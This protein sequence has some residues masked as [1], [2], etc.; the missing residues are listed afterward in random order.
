MRESGN[1]FKLRFLSQYMKIDVY[2]HKQ[3]YENW[4]RDVVE[5][6]EEGLT[7]ENS[8]ILIQFIFDMEIGANVSKSSKKGPR[9]YPRLNNLRL[10]LAQIMRRLEE[11]G[12]DDITKKNK[13]FF[14]EL[15][16]IVTKLFSNMKKGV[17]K[18]HRGEKY[19]S[20]ADY[21]KVFKA[22]WNWH[23]KLNRKKNIIIPDITEDLD[24]T[25]NDSKFVWIKK[26]Q[27]NKYRIY[28]D[29]DEQT[30]ILFMFDSI[31]RAPTELLSLRVQ[32][33]FQR[34]GEVWVNIPDEISKTFGRSFNLVYSGKAVLDYIKRT[35]LKAED[36]LFKFSAP[37]FN[38]KLQK[39]AKQLYKN[40]MSEGGEYYKNITLYDLR[41]SGT[42]HFRQLFQ[43]TG[44]SLDSLRHRGGW[45]NFKMINYYTKLL[46]LDGHIAR[47]KLLLE[48]DRTKLEKEV[49]SLKKKYNHLFNV[50]K[51]IDSSAVKSFS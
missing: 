5:G 25:P 47:E 16:E 17:I 30:L 1:I 22:F 23:R 39:I 27:L 44:Q 38:K 21:V 15:Q 48:E 20:T 8:D 42:I 35:N 37:M 26:E 18:T 14:P 50:I 29:E 9:S 10:R 7:K 34:N 32:D 36:S 51:K 43:K 19:K 11:R 31:I 49:E 4:K 24:T 13:A 41:H 3:R 46:G 2:G 33:I 12:I 45:T 28:F 6:G 40:T